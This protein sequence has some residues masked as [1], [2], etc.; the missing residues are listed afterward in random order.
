MLCNGELKSEVIPVDI[1][2]NGLLL[3]PYYFTQLKERPAQL[4]VFNLTVHESQKRTWKWVMDKGREYAE[5]YPFE[6][7]FMHDSC[8]ETY[9]HRLRSLQ[10]FTTRAWD[11]KSNNFREIFKSLGDEDR[12]IFKINT[13]DVD[14][15]E[16]LKNSILGG[17]QYVMK[18]PLSTIP[19]ARVQHK[20]MYV[21]D[22]RFDLRCKRVSM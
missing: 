2:I 12:K 6:V 11:F 22:R 7:W 4:P 1:A 18:E 14:E 13:E 21:L 10:F 19:K 5:K 15:N 8:P 3:I 20:C 16:Y 9:C 17:R